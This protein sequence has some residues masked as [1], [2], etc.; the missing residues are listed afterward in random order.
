MAAALAND[1]GFYSAVGAVD[2][3]KVAVLEEAAV[4]AAAGTPERALVLATLCS[5][6]AFG[7]TL[8]RRRSLADEAVDL[9]RELHDDTVLVRVLN[10]V[11]VALMV[12][13]LLEESV[14]RT[15]EALERALRVGDPVQVSWS[16][17]WRA[18]DAV[19]S[20]DVEELDRCIDL[21]G[22]MVEQLDQPVF[23]WDHTFLRAMQAQVAGDAERAEELATEALRIGTECGQP[24]AATIFGAQFIVA[25]GQR[26]T[27]SELAPLIEEMAAHTPDISRWLFA[28]LLAKAHVEGDRTGPAA[29]LLE[30]FAAAGFEL[31]LDQIWL[32]GMVDFAEAAIEVGDPAFAGP[33]FDRLESLGDQLA[34]TGGSALA[35]VS[36]YLGGLAAVLGRPDDADARFAR[37]A[38]ISVRLRAKFFLAQTQ[39]RWGRLLAGRDG[40]GD[41]DRAR[42]LLGSALATATD[43]GYG[44]V[45]RRAAAALD[46]LG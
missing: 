36:Y 11:H 33:L 24:D 39:L 3:D 21:H 31:P 14:A 17:H 15:T 7:S 45:R 42:E 27:M 10:H 23:T 28:S 20:G 16:A 34:A 43:H 32:T 30:E 5:E 6:L 8:E 44:T 46:A 9:A 12:P 35:P 40:P 22:R 29:T 37:A 1:R 38:D 18:A 4:Q 41:R 25:S 26:G 2:T 19:R 13:S